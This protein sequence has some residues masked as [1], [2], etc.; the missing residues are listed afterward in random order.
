MFKIY[1]NRLIISLFYAFVFISN[2]YAGDVFEQL[3]T[4]IHENEKYVFYSHGFIVEGT[5]PTPVSTRWGKYDFPQI[6]KSL[7]DEQYNL[8]AYHRA[9]GTDPRAFAKKLA[10]DIKIL[11][12][13]GVQ[14]Q[15]IYMVGFSRGGAI[16]VLT[17]NEVRSKKINSII[18]AGCGSFVT[19][20]Q[21]VKVYG[22]VHSI[23]ETSDGVGSCQHLIN[24]SD[25]VQSFEEIAISTGK[26]HG[27]FY[28]PIPEWVVPVKN[29]IKSPKN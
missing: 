15:N 5:N 13:S 12:E 17:S 23:Y 29:W 20:N 19:T 9:K 4:K 7:A 27:A 26:G 21:D 10:S 18:L 24:R 11:V 22:N 25:K 1:K 8:I 6:K 16:T 28:N 2:S 14:Y 3:P